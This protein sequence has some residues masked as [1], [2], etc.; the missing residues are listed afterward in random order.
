MRLLPDNNIKEINGK[1]IPCG[2]G[3]KGGYFQICGAGTGH[4]SP[5][6]LGMGR[7]RILRSGAEN[8]AFPVKAYKPVIS[9]H[10]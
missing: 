6:F 9:G 10:G 7:E 1:Y 4:L 2:W 5:P 3:K 8:C